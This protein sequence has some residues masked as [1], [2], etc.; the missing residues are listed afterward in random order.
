MHPKN[1]QSGESIN[2]WIES[3]TSTKESFDAEIYDTLSRKTALF[4]GEVKDVSETNEPLYLMTLSEVGGAACDMSKLYTQFSQDQLT[5]LNNY[6][7]FIQLATKECE[8]AQ[9]SAKSLYL[10]V[11]D[12]PQLK[13]INEQEGYAKGDQILMHTANIL[14]ESTDESMIVARLEGSRFGILLSKE[15]SQELYNWSMIV[16]NRLN[17][18]S[19]RRSVAFTYFDTAEGL[20]KSELRAY[21]LIDRVNSSDENR[22]MTD[23]EGVEYID[24]SQDKI[25]ENLRDCQEIDGALL[26]QELVVKS[27]AKIVGFKGE[28]MALRL[29]AKQLLFVKEGDTLY[30]QTKEL[31]LIQ[32]KILEL[33]RE[34]SEALI[35]EFKSDINSPLK[36]KR[37]RVAASEELRVSV[38]YDT[39][40]IDTKLLNLNDKFM[41]LYAKRRR[42]L[43]E[44]ELVYLDMMV[45]SKNKREA[46]SIN[47]IIYKLEAMDEGYKI[48]LLCQHNHHSQNLIDQYI[49]SRQIEI[50]KELSEL[51]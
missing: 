28:T 46:L 36:R 33:M 41:A 50:I 21:S 15:S 22:V 14:R 30:A 23:I 45:S 34:R 6:A 10:M 43:Q 13:S 12:I 4:Y 51:A 2:D 42:T 3:I 48:V 17:K 25:L 29:S 40:E 44:S 20:N 37:V 9:K 11:V 1:L 32:A 38:L 16:K 24:G 31:G 49:A 5:L 7:T 39:L 18:D 27:H 19:Y 35:G 26:F 47:A 8:A